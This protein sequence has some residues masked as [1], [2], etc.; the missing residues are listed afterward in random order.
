M[1]VYQRVSAKK[2]TGKTWPDEGARNARIHSFRK[3]CVTGER[4][5]YSKWKAKVR[6]KPYGYGSIPIHTIFRGWTSINPS[7]FDVNYRGTRFW[8][9]AILQRKFE[10]DWL[11]WWFQHIGPTPDAQ[12]RTSI[13]SLPLEQRCV[14]LTQNNG[15]GTGMAWRV[16]EKS[17]SVSSIQHL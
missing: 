7:Y 6:T 14:L 1:L 10:N 15:Y 11:N 13:A 3:T 16:G 12:Y 2:T 17:W 8:H 9:T 4:C 5:H